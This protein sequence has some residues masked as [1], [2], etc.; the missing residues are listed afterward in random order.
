MILSPGSLSSLT[1]T[2]RLAYGSAVYKAVYEVYKARQGTQAA[3][4]H[5]TREGTKGRGSPAPPA[6]GR[7]VLAYVCQRAAGGAVPHARVQTRAAMRTE[8][9]TVVAAPLFSLR[10]S[11][12]SLSLS[13]CF[14]RRCVSVAIAFPLSL[15][16]HCHCRLLSHHHRHRIVNCV[17]KPASG[18]DTQ[19]EPNPPIPACNERIPGSDAACCGPAL[20]TSIIGGERSGNGIF[21]GMMKHTVWLLMLVASGC[22]WAEFYTL[23]TSR[24]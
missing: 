13:L 6:A 4:L 15:P 12:H 17:M 20:Y 2:P 7:P 18:V 1:F 14:R 9:K 22:C 19:R 21:R 8:A 5:S 24:E 10:M 23:P 11:L 3:V 16:F